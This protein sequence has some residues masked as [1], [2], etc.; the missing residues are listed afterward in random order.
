MF[1]ASIYSARIYNAAIY[2]APGGAPPTPTPTGSKGRRL[3]RW[4]INSP[5][6]PNPLGEYVW[7]REEEDEFYIVFG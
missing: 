1:G 3:V 4:V 6:I 2:A 7:R 5:P